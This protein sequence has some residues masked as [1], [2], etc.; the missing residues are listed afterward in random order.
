MLNDLIYNIPSLQRRP[1]YP[2]WH[3]FWQVPSIWTQ[4]DRSEQWPQ[5]DEQFNPYFPNAHSKA[6]DIDS[7]SWKLHF[8]SIDECF[9]G[10]TTILLEKWYK[11]V[12]MYLL[13]LQLWPKYPGWH[14]VKQDPLMKLHWLL[15]RQCPHVSLHRCPYWPIVHAAKNIRKKYGKKNQ[16]QQKYQS[17]NFHELF[18]QHLLYS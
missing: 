16:I 1:W 18:S 3:P 5:T 10:M 17:L 14:P 7:K 15:S 12:N 2:D 8:I 4:S 13:S 9:L 11:Q 6:I